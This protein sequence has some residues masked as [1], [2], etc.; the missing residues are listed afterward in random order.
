[1]VTAANATKMAA[2]T[3]HTRRTCVLGPDKDKW[4]AA[5]YAQP[6]K[7]HSYGMWGDAIACRDVPPD[8]KIVRPIWNYTQKGS[9]EHKASNCMDGK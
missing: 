7:H 1:M 5:E 4:M 8:A 6:D 2:G 3:K 9:G